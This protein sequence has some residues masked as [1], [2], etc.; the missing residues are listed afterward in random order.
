MSIA[1]IVQSDIQRIK[2]S[3][4]Q[5]SV[6]NFIVVGNNQ[7][8]FGTVCAVPIDSFV[9][10]FLIRTQLQFIVGKG[11]KTIIICLFLLYS[12]VINVIVYV[13]SQV[14]TWMNYLI[15]VHVIDLIVVDDDI[16][17]YLLQTCFRF[18]DVELYLLRMC[19][20]CL[21]NLPVDT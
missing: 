4:P 10:V 14:I 7:F 3:W 19:L 12:L 17:I 20:R 15:V 2:Y 1:V 13:I 18:V 9:M 6:S 21:L 5:C 16:E 11:V 8:T